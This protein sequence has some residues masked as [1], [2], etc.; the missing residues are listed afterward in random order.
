MPRLEFSNRFAEDLAQIYSARLEMQI[1]DNL[2]YLELF[3]EF[4]S[5]N[6]PKSI[7]EEFGEGVRKVPINPFDLIYTYY[8]DQDLIR[9]EAL[10]HQRAAW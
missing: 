6:L 9:V 2:N 8:P 4:G 10:V 1:L 3:E 5:K 7:I